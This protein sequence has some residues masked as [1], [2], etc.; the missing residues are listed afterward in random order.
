MAVKYNLVQKQNPLMEEKPKKWYATT[1]TTKSLDRKEITRMA[2]SNTSISPHEMEAALEIL[3]DFIPDQLHL[4]N[5]VSI[6]GLG[7]FMVSFRSDGAENVTDF[8]PNSMIKNPRIKF[9][10]S[11][12]F[13]AKVL[14]GLKFV[15]GGVLEDGISYSSVTDYRKAKGLITDD[16]DSPDEI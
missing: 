8:N 1:M 5:S 14:N 4:G 2:T 7:T 10:P 12:N 13:R 9:I 6:P 11:N 3:A 16:S 15:N